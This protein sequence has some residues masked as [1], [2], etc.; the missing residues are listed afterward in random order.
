M[1]WLVARFSSSWTDLLSYAE[2]SNTDSVYFS[3]S[4]LHLDS[5]V[6]LFWEILRDVVKVHSIKN[7]PV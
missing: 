1:R 2:V 7:E 6:E 4:V 5:Y 3:V